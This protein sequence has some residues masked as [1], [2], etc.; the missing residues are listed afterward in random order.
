MAKLNM[1]KFKTCLPGTSRV[2]IVYIPMAKH[3]IFFYKEQ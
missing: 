2:V 1:W 3:K